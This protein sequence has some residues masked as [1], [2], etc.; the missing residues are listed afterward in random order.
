MGLYEKVYMIFSKQNMLQRMYTC[1]SLY[2]CVRVQL[3][4]NCNIS[5]KGAIFSNCARFVSLMTFSVLRNNCMLIYARLRSQPRYFTVHI[6]H[7][8]CWLFFHLPVFPILRPLNFP[9]TSHGCLTNLTFFAPASLTN[10]LMNSVLSSAPALTT[11]FPLLS[12]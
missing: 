1:D 10:N 6:V 9:L 12:I 2:I 3:F 7:R 11:S 8:I 5:I 4:F